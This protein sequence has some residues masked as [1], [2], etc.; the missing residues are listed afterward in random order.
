YIGDTLRLADEE[1][2]THITM[3]IMIGKAVKLAEG[4]LDTHSRNVVMNRDFITSLAAESHC[5]P[6]N[7]ARV[8]E[9]TLARELWEL[10]TDTPA[11]FTLLVDRCMTVCRPLLSHA[12]LEIMLVPEQA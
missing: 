2:I 4:H 10:F 5:H 1:G 11:F 8:A 7:I 12:T 9:I 6:A 3:G